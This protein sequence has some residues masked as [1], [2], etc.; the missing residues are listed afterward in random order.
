VSR[1]T[2]AALAVVLTGCASVFESDAPVWHAYVLEP[3]APPA[4]SLAIAPLPATLRVARPSAAPGL[5]SDRI[6]IVMPDR[7]L[8]FFANARWAGALPDVLAAF[9]VETLRSGGG[10]QGV[11]AESL[12]FPADYLLTLHVRRFEA[13]Y[14]RPGSAPRVHVAIDAVFGRRIERTVVARFTAESSVEAAE[15]RIGA[16]VAAFESAT[17]E[18]MEQVRARTLEAAARTSRDPSPP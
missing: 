3:A 9:A 14:S 13:E 10:F 2:A 16:V 1:W 12:P 15:N 17:R 11:Q 5:D 18:A 4:A 7:Q 6:R 8:D